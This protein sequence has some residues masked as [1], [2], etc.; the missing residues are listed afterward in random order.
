[1]HNSASHA[2]VHDPQPVC[3][4][5]RDGLP[6]DHRGEFWDLVREREDGAV[7]ALLREQRSGKAVAAACTHLYHDP[8]FPDVKAAQAELLCQQA[9]CT[10][11]P[12]SVLPASSAE[13]LLWM[14][15]AMQQLEGS[16]VCMQMVAF[17][18]DRGHN[19]SGTPLVQPCGEGPWEWTLHTPAACACRVPTPALAC[20]HLNVNVNQHTAG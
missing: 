20:E 4:S 1:M 6:A 2:G 8:R 13:V 10:L 11:T 5:L 14:V 16:H 15:L 17:L 7:F 9:G 19:P 3:C 12:L 18:K